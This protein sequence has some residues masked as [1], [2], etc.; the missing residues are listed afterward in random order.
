MTNNNTESVLSH[1][2]LRSL[3][4][5]PAA[6][7][8]LE[9]VLSDLEALAV[10]VQFLS[11]KNL[12]LDPKK[13]RSEVTLDESRPDLLI[14][15]GDGKHRLMIENKFWAGLTDAQPNKYLEHLPK[16]ENGAALVFIVPISRM[17]SIWTELERRSSFE[18][19]PISQEATDAVISAQ[20]PDNRVIAV[21]SWEAVLDRLRTLPQ[22]EVDVLQLRAL[23]DEINHLET[24]LPIQVDEP[25]D[26]DLARRF[27][28]YT[29]L[30]DQIASELTSR[31]KADTKGVG[32]AHTY[33][34]IGRY[35]TMNNV[36]LT[37]RK[38]GFWFGVELELWR[39]TGITP[40]WWVVF[41]TD[42][43]NIGPVW[44]NMESLFDDLQHDENHSAG[45]RKCLPI[46]LKTGVDHGRV[47]EDAADQMIKIAD[48]ILEKLTK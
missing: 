40:L 43:G 14:Y 8:A 5:E 45:E 15:D 27:I 42:W 30:V 37:D 21:T 19:E 17:R 33:R 46:R 22:V 9:Y 11:L 6:T 36:S 26:V 28:N 2:V 39:T 48:R 31:G 38:I 41:N 25:T 34:S 12:T 29:D 1:V 18:F 23:V 20:L 7:L 13:V 47:V 10:F 44:E 16:S 24:F 4:P 35:L 3:Q 32:V